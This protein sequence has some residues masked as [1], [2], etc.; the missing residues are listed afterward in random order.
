MRRHPLVDAAVLGALVGGA[1]AIV[2]ASS[3]LDAWTWQ[4]VGI[5]LAI[6]VVAALVAGFARRLSPRRRA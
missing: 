6:A 4:T 2:V 1:A 5:V 3:G